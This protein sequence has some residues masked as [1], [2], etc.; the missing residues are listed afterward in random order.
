MTTFG[1]KQYAPERV[2]LNTSNNRW[3]LLTAVSNS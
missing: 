2:A 3:Q 1:D